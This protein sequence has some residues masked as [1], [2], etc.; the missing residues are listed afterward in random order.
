MTLQRNQSWIAVSVIYKLLVK[1]NY[2][3]FGFILELVYNLFI[4]FKANH[5]WKKKFTREESYPCRCCNMIHIVLK[6]CPCGALF[7]N[8]NSSKWLIQTIN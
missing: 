2:P 7:K 6:L 5:F 4:A 8:K 1:I 3:E